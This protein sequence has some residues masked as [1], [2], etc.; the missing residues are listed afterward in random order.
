MQIHLRKQSD[1]REVELLLSEVDFKFG[2]DTFRLDSSARIFSPKN[3]D[4][5]LWKKPKRTITA[6]PAMKANKR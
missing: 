1:Y 3:F 6:I 4:R 2:A 5:N